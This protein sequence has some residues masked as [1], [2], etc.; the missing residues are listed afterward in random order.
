MFIVAVNFSLTQNNII[1][2]KREWVRWR[3]KFG[4][5]RGGSVVK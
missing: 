3:D 5:G 2:Y 4:V 1:Q